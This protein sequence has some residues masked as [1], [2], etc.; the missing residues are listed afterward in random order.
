MIHWPYYVVKLLRIKFLHTIFFLKKIKNSVVLFMYTGLINGA[1]FL[2]QSQVRNFAVSKT[3]RPTLVYRLSFKIPDKNIFNLVLL[4]IISSIKRLKLLKLIK[5]CGYTTRKTF[6]TVLRSPFVHKK[7]REQ[8][9][10][11]LS[12]GSI[13][14]RF[15]ITNYLVINFIKAYF[16]VCLKKLSAFGFKNQIKMVL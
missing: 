15:C 2:L 3:V 1:S 5:F 6:Y 9:L 16:T 8:F 14:V 10:T 12:K 4:D 13:S 7:S 11:V